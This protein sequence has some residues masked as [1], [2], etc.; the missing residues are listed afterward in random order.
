MDIPKTWY[1]GN[2]CHL[3]QI[4]K[5]G[6]EEIVIYKHWM[7]HRQRWNY[8]AEERWLVEHM[9]QREKQ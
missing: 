3:V 6:D 9:I 4:I 8:V 1:W 7:R 2:K 5:D